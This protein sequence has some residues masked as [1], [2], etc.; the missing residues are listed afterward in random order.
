MEAEIPF[1]IDDALLAQNPDALIITDSVGRIVH[2]NAGAVG[3]FGRQAESTRGQPLASLLPEGQVEEFQLA[4]AHTQRHGEARV[5]VVARQS[6]ASLAYVDFIARRLDELVTGHILW[7][8]RD[9][10]Q[11]RLLRASLHLQS[12]YGELIESTPDG[13]LF[14]GETG[15]ILLANAN[16]ERLFGYGRDELQGKPVDILVPH[17]MR[18]GH[19]GHRADYLRQPH[20]RSMAAG[21]ELQGRR[22]DGEEFPVEVSLSPLRTEEGLVVI[23]A[24]R[25]VTERV[26]AARMFRELLEAAPD[27]IVI[28]DPSGTIVLANSQTDAL[29]GYARQ[30]LIGRPVEVLMPERFRD[31]HVGHRRGFDVQPRVRVMGEGLELFARRKDGTEFPV[32]VS[33][34]PICT[35]DGRLTSAAIR[36][37]T[38]RRAVAQQLQEQNQKLARA[39][40]AKTNFLAGMSHELRTPLNA[41]IGFTGTL[42]MK[43]PGPLNDEQEKQLRTVQWAGQHLLTMIND[44]LDLTRIESGETHIDRAPVP[45]V[46]VAR[47]AGSQ[48]RAQAETKGLAL[49]LELPEEEVVVPTDRRALTQILMNLTANAVKYTESGHVRLRVVRA[50]PW[51]RFEVSDTGIGIRPE[52][53]E[54]LFK[55]FSRLERGNETRQGTGL[56]L[57]LS[58]RLAALLGG[59]VE[60]ES[61]VG[62]GSMFTLSLPES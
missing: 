25:D 56:G 51:V 17:G 28:T 47:A 41:I 13:M 8:G 42:L 4:L 22:K 52:D 43:L 45:C 21:V 37:I 30:E 26:N 59:H 12:R 1:D 19:V 53:R 5:E 60:F 62:A 44:L 11:P 31:P 14:I 10:T 61:V 15:H 16:A 27:A 35:A 6:G 46:E 34:S 3:V 36:D 50:S 32:E 29:F 20:V 57:Y 38:A 7:S 33:L 40:E 23:S 18:P 2:W 49:E 39:S 48:L 54:K 24:V 55:A 9:V 58:A